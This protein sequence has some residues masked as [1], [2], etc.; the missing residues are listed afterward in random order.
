MDI[1]GK[2]ALV[3]GGGHRV[4]RAITL[5]LAQLGANV[6]VNYNTSQAAADE[7]AQQ[8]QDHGVAAVALQAD[9][10]DWPAVQRMAGEIET[11]FGG[12]DI[13]VN[14]ASLFAR[15]PFPT[16]DLTTWRRVVATSVDGPF[17]VCNRLAPG[18]A[19][20]GG[21]AIVNI[22]DLSAFEPWPNF[23]AHSVGK[24]GLLALTRQ[25]ALELAPTIR[26]NAVAPGPVL[27]APEHDER[28]QAAVAARTLLKRWGI[29]EDVARAVRYLI[30]A[31]YVTGDVMT[32]DGGERFG[33][34]KHPAS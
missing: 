18:M 29:P 25:L 27:P 16:A 13:I 1:A 20:R 28:R 33:P 34:R 26:V 21:G 8:A 5:M 7:T 3:T 15:T 2:V 31:D 23:M 24:A 22:V 12:V 10:A 19:A 4:G 17:H 6:V 9:V 14:S 30:E 11:R 32:V